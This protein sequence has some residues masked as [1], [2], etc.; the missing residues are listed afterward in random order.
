MLKTFALIFYLLYLFI[1]YLI[2]QCFAAQEI[3]IININ[4]ENSCGA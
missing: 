3:F 1:I 4:V 2:F